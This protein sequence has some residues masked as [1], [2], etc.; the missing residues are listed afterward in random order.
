M[1]G[2]RVLEI[3]E[4][5]KIIEL[6]ING[7]KIDRGIT[8][9]PNKQAALVL[10]LQASLGLRIGDVLKLKGTNFRNGKLEITEEKTGKL[11]YRDINPAVSDRVK[12]YI[13]GRKLDQNDILFKITPRAVQ[14]KLAK[15]T[16]YLG[17]ENIST[18]SFRKMFATIVYEQNGNNIEL[19]KELLNHTSIAT[20]QRYIR[21]SQK[22]INEASAKVCFM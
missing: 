5:Q 9:R 6:M 15:I 17:L 3:D 19:L 10:Q 21:T 16:D 2:C 1:A 8:I 20:T 13:I 12:D 18:H 7:I 14:K 22:A 11:Q 4:Y